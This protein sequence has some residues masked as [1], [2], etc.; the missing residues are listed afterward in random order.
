M[1]K[2]DNKFVGTESIKI[3]TTNAVFAHKKWNEYLETK[4]KEGVDCTS[5][6]LINVDNSKEIPFTKEE[7]DEN[8]RIENKYFNK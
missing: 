2:K 3:D 1:L 7:L 8:I 6:I 4:R 5:S